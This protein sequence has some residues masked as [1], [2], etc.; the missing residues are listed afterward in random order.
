MAMKVKC[1]KCGSRNVCEFLYGLPTRE[2]FELAEQGKLILA[3]C[4]IVMDD[5]SQPDYGCLDCKYEWAPELL[6]ASDIIK[7]RFKV[8]TSLEKS[9]DLQQYT[10]H[11]IFPDGLVRIYRYEGISRKATDK[12]VK[13]ID[14]EEVKKLSISLQKYLQIPLFAREDK[15]S[16]KKFD[17]QISYTDGR[18]VVVKSI[19]EG[20]ESFF[21]L[22]MRVAR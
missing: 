22:M 9:G 21:A 13:W 7:I 18:K 19:D 16:E 5:L 4:E 6:P 17:L 14:K 11:K 1:P 8:W 10:V 12:Q 2:A 20:A 15:H 3:G